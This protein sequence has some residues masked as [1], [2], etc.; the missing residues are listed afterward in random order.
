MTGHATDEWIVDDHG[1]IYAGE[2]IDGSPRPLIIATAWKEDA[3]HGD[4]EAIEN[5]KRA[6]ACVKACVAMGDD[7]VEGVARICEQHIES[8]KLAVYLTEKVERLE[9]NHRDFATKAEI[10]LKNDSIEIE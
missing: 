1:I 7:P 2:N 6:A 9:A 4:D 5:A 3:W 8:E 10:T